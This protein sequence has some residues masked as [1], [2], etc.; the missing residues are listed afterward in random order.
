MK[1]LGLAGWSGSG[2]T[3]LLGT[4]IPALKARGLSVSTIKHAHRHF[5]IDHPGKDSFAH[6][7]AG[8]GEVLIASGGRW[9]LMHEPD[10]AAC[11][12]GEPGLGDLLE[13][14]SPVDL[15]LLEGFRGPAHHHPKI[16]VH[17]QAN[18]KPFLFPD[19]P[20]IEAL[21]SDGPPPDCALP[22]FDP[23]DP[24][25]L[26]DFICARFGVDHG[27]RPGRI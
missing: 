23:D 2:K 17:R 14:L 3:T 8:A 24:A 15:V 20:R 21:V 12:A 4:L 10:P 7:E 16:E 11:P 13:K 22:I 5:E 1:V 6:R 26:A 19:D 18:G 27:A 25:P 9:A